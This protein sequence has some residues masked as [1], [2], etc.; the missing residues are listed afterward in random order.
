MEGLAL[1][2]VFCSTLAALV[3]VIPVLCSLIV[4]SLRGWVIMGPPGQFALNKTLPARPNLGFTFASPSLFSLGVVHPEGHLY[5]TPR[6]SAC[7]SVGP[8]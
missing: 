2:L 8:N 3:S 4:H 1:C 7:L 5:F 6:A